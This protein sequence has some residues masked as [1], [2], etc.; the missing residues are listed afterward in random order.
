L[1]E[2]NGGGKAGGKRGRKGARPRPLAPRSPD[3]GSS[4]VTTDKLRERDGGASWQLRKEGAGRY[5]HGAV[6][7]ENVGFRVWKVEHDLEGVR[8]T[9]FFLETLH[10][11]GNG[12]VGALAFGQEPGSAVPRYQEIDFPAREL[13]SE[14]KY[15]FGFV[16]T[17]PSYTLF[18]MTLWR[19]AGAETTPF[20]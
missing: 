6:Q 16:A 14:T 11:G 15:Y 7:P 8:H 10:R 13:S 4:L 12:R 17:F 20:Q 9:D 19:L 1:R 5:R 3:P 2:E 18:W